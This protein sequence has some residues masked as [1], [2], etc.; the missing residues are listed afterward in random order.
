MSGKSAK[1]VRAL[2]K[3]ELSKEHIDPNKGMI[4]A[5]TRKYQTIPRTYRSYVK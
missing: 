2:V 1:R 3:R 4:R 5:A